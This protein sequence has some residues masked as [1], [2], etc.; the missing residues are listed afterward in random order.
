MKPEQPVA[1]AGTD[2]TSAPER[3]TEP[4]FS[5]V[6]SATYGPRGHD[7]TTSASNS[8]N[9][10]SA[11]DR[12]LANGPS[13][14]ETQFLDMDTGSV[15]VGASPANSTETAAARTADTGK[16][17]DWL[18]KNFKDIDMDGDG[19]LT[20][21]EL[22]AA[23]M[24]PKLANGEGGKYL[25]SAYL[26]A[27]SFKDAAADLRKGPEAETKTDGKTDSVKPAEGEEVLPPPP[28]A[29]GRRRTDPDPVNAEDSKD[30]KETKA[31]DGFT[32][33]DLKTL[34]EHL[35][36]LD[37]ADTKERLQVESIADFFKHIDGNGD[38]VVTRPELDKALKRKDWSED[39]RKSLE[40]F[41][42]KFTKI[43]AASD[44]TVPMILTAGGVYPPR[45][46]YPQPE[47]TSAGSPPDDNAVP[48]PEPEWASIIDVEK[49]AGK[50]EQFLNSVGK[51]LAIRDSHMKEDAQ[52]QTGSCF[53]VSTIQEVMSRN[54]EAINKMIKDN[55]DG[56]STVTFPGDR[57]NP[58]TVSNPTT[59]ERALYSSGEKTAIL[60]KAFALKQV[61][62]LAD[63][64]EYE[65][66]DGK[67]KTPLQESLQRGGDARD[68][69]GL[70]T[71]VE[72][73]EATIP[74]AASDEELRAFLAKSND[75]TKVMVTGSKESTDS[76]II[77][78][79]AYA[80]TG[81]NEKTGEVELRNPYNASV[82][83]NQSE[84]V[85]VRGEALDGKV[86][87]RF[88]ISLDDFKKNFYKTSVADIVKK[89]N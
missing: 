16:M 4:T 31:P 26:R 56:T 68:F 73:P 35:P 15:L 28:P 51:S 77:S 11:S 8:S 14:G 20:K 86:D 74:E 5:D 19:H 76:G 3:R 69:L 12:L 71:G 7:A 72:K 29:G 36:N 1:Q 57:E 13:T 21:A 70:L 41:D 32:Q 67:P 43:A 50:G 58:L 34:R 18:G 80:I 66:K 62:E 81:F 65:G 9:V 46:L 10:A 49:Y 59:A 52:G 60:E 83:A 79:H 88:K 38:N 61:N 6:I 84:P 75:S 78:E 2:H 64:S 22:G 17:M 45:V 30:S 40:L 24:N 48:K 53:A 23:T 25:A 63:K 85:N 87:G 33:E 39:Q 82:D 27:D 42:K 55:G 54:P 37:K 44:D 89:G 47:E